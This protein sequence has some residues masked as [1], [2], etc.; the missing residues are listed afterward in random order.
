MRLA[1]GVCLVVAV[2][3]VSESEAA[4]ARGIFKD[5]AHPGKCVLKGLILE[6]G[7]SARNPKSCERILCGENSTVEIH[8]CGAYGLPPG[9]KFGK[10]KTPNADY[11]TCCEREIINV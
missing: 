9:K 5:P 1:I 2:L 11:P 8:T 4:V 7:Q 3:L 10:Y 6:A